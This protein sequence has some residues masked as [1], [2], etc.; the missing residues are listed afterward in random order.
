[1]SKRRSTHLF[2]AE[3]ERQAKS[4]QKRLERR[5]SA[6]PSGLGRPPRISSN[7]SNGHERCGGIIEHSLLP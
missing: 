3:K 7:R 2:Q 5:R 1:M 6:S 4:V